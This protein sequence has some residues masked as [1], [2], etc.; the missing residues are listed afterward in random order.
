VDWYPYPF[1]D[2]RTQGYLQMAI[3]LVVLLLAML[4]MSL[5][6]NA[7]GRIAGEWRYGSSARRSA[8]QLSESG[9]SEVEQ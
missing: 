5:A 4:L 8:A 1:I 6:V 9:E 2:P 3:G 7:A